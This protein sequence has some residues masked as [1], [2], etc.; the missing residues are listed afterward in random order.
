MLRRV[1]CCYGKSSVCLSVRLTVTLGHRDHIGWNSSKIISWLVGLFRFLQTQTSWIYSNNV[2]LLQSE[3]P[4]F[5]IGIGVYVHGWGMKKGLSV[6]K[7]CNIS[8]TGQDRTKVAICYYDTIR[9]DTIEEF[10]VDSKAEYS[11]LSIAHVAR[12]RN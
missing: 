5:F 11:A 6:Y 10:N 1:R 7:S 4:E 2:H 8:E 9:Y 12:K 3:H